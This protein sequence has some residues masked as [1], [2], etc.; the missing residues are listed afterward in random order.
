MSNLKAGLIA[1]IIITASVWLAGC[2]Q[3]K[4]IVS[5]SDP[6]SGCIDS[7]IF[8]DKQVC[9]QVE[10]KDKVQPVEQKVNVAPSAVK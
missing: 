2:D 9:I 3:I 7:R 5:N 6:V 4:Q 10:Y 8:A 1:S